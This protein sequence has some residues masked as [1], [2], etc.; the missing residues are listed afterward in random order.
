PGSPGPIDREV[1]AKLR[2]LNIAPSGP[3]SDEE[4]LR[5]VSLDA[6][7]SLPT[8]D[9]VRAFLADRRPDKRARKIDEL[10]AHPRHAA[11]WA[12]KVC[13]IAGC[14]VDTMD[15]PPE[16]R[17][18]HAQM[19]HDWFRT[20][21]AANVSYDRIARGVL[22]ATSRDGQDVDA[23]V[24]RDAATEQAARAGFAAPY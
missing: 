24:N 20:R 6:I 13:D 5:R 21:V 12:T 2:R 11:P 8:P 7:G 14:N 15:G 17:A 16:L 1:F 3:A 19:W 10:L 18:K 22:L 23:W 4:F 9:E